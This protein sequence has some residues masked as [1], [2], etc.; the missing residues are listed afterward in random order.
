MDSTETKLAILQSH[1]PDSSPDQL[2][3]I[4]VS[5]DGD[6]DLAL[7]LLGVRKRKSAGEG[8]GLGH[9][10]TLRKFLKTE[11]NSDQLER[12]LSRK[13][14]TVHLYDPKD[15]EAL[16]PCTLHL[17]IL[18][19]KLADDLLK[20]LLKDS[21]GWAQNRFHM[22][23]RACAS[24]HTTAV[25]TSSESVRESGAS[26]NGAVSKTIRPFDDTMKQSRDIVE[27]VVN[28][29]IKRRGL[30]KYQY[31]GPWSSDVAVCNR[32]NG[33]GDSV[34]YHSDQMTHIGP[35]S[36]IASLS[37]GPTREFRLKH[38]HHR[39]RAPV[40]IHVPHNSMVIM[41]AGCQ[42]EYK[43]SLIPTARPLSPHP[44]SGV[45]RLN[46]TYRMYLDDFK[47]D[48]VPKCDC[49]RV[50][51]LRTTVDPSMNYKYIWQ[52]GDSYQGGQGCSKLI[53]PKFSENDTPKSPDHHT[54]PPI[55]LS[56]VKSPD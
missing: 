51:I 12:A 56:P 24:G 55:K 44:I 34:G 38:R 23:D 29:E 15:V 8:A 21:E 52:C 47:I 32:Y 50:M 35:H 22:F 26:Y 19:P 48:K 13:G 49:N 7:S 37:L 40:S 16:L 1:V 3:D 10:T 42:E 45:T 53:Y 4:L 14:Q 30:A 9:Q 39:D 31:P 20:F 36:V 2:L 54:T 27:K 25:Y 43:H 17:N 11:S 18:P 5:C 28:R 46:V 6:V 41:H 33:G